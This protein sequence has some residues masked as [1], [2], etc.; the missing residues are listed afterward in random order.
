MLTKSPL[1]EPTK[2]TSSA[3]ETVSADYGDLD[4]YLNDGLGLGAP[5]RAGLKARYLAS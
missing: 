2:T 4:T 1:T 3:F 5:E